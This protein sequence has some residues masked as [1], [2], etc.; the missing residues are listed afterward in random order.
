MSKLSLAWRAV[1]IN[2]LST[3][4]INKITKSK[5]S[6][7]NQKSN[8]SLEIRGNFLFVIKRYWW[9]YGEAYSFWLIYYIN[10]GK[11]MHDEIEILHLAKLSRVMVQWLLYMKTSPRFFE[12]TQSM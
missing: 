3:F 12:S 7:Q 5:V 6:F 11:N 4:W 1:I 9:L 10:T 2:L 8:S